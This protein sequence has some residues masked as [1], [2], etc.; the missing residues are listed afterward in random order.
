MVHDPV[1][2]SALI[3]AWFLLSTSDDFRL[4]SVAFDLFPYLEWKDIPNP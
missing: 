2:L 1:S 3:E 4:C